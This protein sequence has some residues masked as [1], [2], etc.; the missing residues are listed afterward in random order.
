MTAIDPSQLEALVPELTPPVVSARHRWIDLG[1]VMLIA[2]A[3]LVLGSVYALFVPIKGSP[4]S[5]NLRFLIGLVQESGALALMVCLLWRQG[6]SLK[7]IGL[8]FRWLDLPVSFGLL[9]AQWVVFLLVYIVVYRVYEF[10]TG[11]TLHLRD[12]HTIFSNP[13]I[14]L[15]V[16]YLIAAPLFEE[17][18]VRAYLM[19][20][21]MGLSLPVWLVVLISTFLQTSYHLYYGVA[22][23]LCIGATFLVLSIYFAKSKRLVPLI[24][25]HLLWD[26]TASS[27]LFHR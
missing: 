4:E 7:S 13:T 23:A 16:P 9:V 21:L 11:T 17:T 25:T 26:I 27:G 18:I 24:L 19:T 12:P 3:P 14:F 22:G 1:L 5:T 6:R 15:W 10:V 8:S 2:V 20:E